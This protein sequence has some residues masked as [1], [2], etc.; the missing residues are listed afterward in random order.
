MGRFWVLFVSHT[1]SRFQLWFYLY[2]SMWVIHRD[3]LLRLTWGSWACPSEGQ[4]WRWHSCLG[5]RG[6]GSARYSGELVA[7]EAGKM[8]L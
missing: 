3:L 5:D 8:M 7:R 2:F 1:V 6:P 4:V